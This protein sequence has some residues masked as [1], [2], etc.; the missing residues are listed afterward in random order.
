M[1]ITHKRQVPVAGNWNVSWVQPR[2]FLRV[3]TMLATAP[4][5]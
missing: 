3:A 1:V 4:C 2:D 5:N